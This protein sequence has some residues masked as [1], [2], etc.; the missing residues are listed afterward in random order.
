MHMKFI[1]EDKKILPIEQAIAELDSE[2][3]YF[4]ERFIQA[5]KR[6]RQEAIF[7]EWQRF[8]AAN[9]EHYCIH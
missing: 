2:Q 1:Y 9:V 7:H 3:F 4:V 5:E 6:R 8:L